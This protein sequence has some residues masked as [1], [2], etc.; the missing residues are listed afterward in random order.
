[1][2]GGVGVYV[3]GFLVCLVGLVAGVDGCCYAV[4]WWFDSFEFSGC[5]VVDCAAY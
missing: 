2:M 1:M 3:V 4:S 5:I